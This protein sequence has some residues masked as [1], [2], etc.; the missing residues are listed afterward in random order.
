MWPKK[1]DVE[2]LVA[3]ARELS[4]LIA[5]TGRHLNPSQGIAWKSSAS[6]LTTY[7]S[8]HHR[9]G[10]T[11]FQQRLQAAQKQGITLREFD[12]REVGIREDEPS[13]LLSSAL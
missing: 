12:T 11:S 1:M 3:D 6:E 10:G 8:F 9:V 2:Q 5:Q 4:G 7:N 13:R